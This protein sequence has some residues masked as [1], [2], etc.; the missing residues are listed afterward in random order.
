MSQETVDRLM[1]SIPALPG[2]SGSPVVNRKGELIS[3]N[4]ASVGGTQSFNYG[5][6]V[7]HL[8]KLINQ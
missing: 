8:T 1:Y 5:V 4:Y 3:I 7:K 6:R 2:S